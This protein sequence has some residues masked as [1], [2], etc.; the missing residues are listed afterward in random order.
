MREARLSSLPNR[1]ILVLVR[2]IT[3]RKRTE[4]QVNALS[5]RLLQS[6]DEERRR[7]AHEL[8]DEFGQLLAGARITAHRLCAR[9]AG[10]TQEI[11][12][13][14]SRLCQDID[15]AIGSMRVI[16]RGLYPTILDHLGLDAAMDALVSDFQ[17]RT[18]I[19]CNLELEG[20]PFELET[21][22]RRAV[23][24]IVQEALTNVMRH[25]QASEVDVIARRDNSHLHVEI[26]DDGQGMNAEAMVQSTS[27]GLTG[28]RKRAE[29]CEG[30]LS[31]WSEPGKGTA[32]VVEVPLEPTVQ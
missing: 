8:H 24:R 17:D 12:E 1:E 2:D 3:E 4:E 10:E 23:Y 13:L 26:R 7:I 32:I 9:V 25:A 29:I 19:A 6:Q 15:T 22:R 27:Y 11:E 16:Q 31:I 5:L 14:C 30:K 18:G 21:E 28:M 20:E